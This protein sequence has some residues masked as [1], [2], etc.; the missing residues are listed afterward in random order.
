MDAALDLKNGKIDAVVLDELPAK[1]IVA[2]NDD[3]MVLDADLATEE[4][5]IAVKKGNT[6]LLEAIQCHNCTYAGGRHLRIPL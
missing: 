2:Q 5:A 4:Y 1:S 6:E 3:L